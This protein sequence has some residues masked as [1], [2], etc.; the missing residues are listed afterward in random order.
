VV[1]AA[2]IALA[3]AAH[4]AEPRVVPP[5]G[6]LPAA[7]SLD[8]ASWPSEI[9]RRPLTLARGMLEVSAPLGINLS[10]DRVGSP[11]FLSPSLRYGLT[12][13]LMLGVRHV[14][15]LCLNG[16]S[17]GCPDVYN[18][19]GV[20]A[21]WQLLRFRGADVALAVALDA[22]PIDPFLLSAEGRILARWSAGPFA[23]FLAPALNV[24][25]THRGGP[26]AKR[27][28][29]SLPLTTYAFGWLEQLPGNTEYVTLPAT[30][31]VQVIPSMVV[32]G[33]AAV[34]GALSAP[35]G[36]FSDH[37]TIPLGMAVVVTPSAALDV[38]ASLTFTNVF[39]RT[40][41]T[42]FRTPPS[43]RRG[44][45]RGLYVFAVFRP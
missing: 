39:G 17:N 31:Q 5:A 13:R 15:G 32:A 41:P 28:A 16:E 25:L 42:P 35:G 8:R 4:G 29:V 26:A 23:L 6:P 45:V 38:G 37:Y 24:G 3:G 14:L 36:D 18:D 21:V 12:D 2:W 34:N 1:L 30:V 22:A 7:S 19:L 43:E 27:V 40:Q 9:V 33:G 20:Q 11:V 44:E 10:S